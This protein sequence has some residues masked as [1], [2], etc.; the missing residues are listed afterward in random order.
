MSFPFELVC[1]VM[2]LIKSRN[3]QN[4]KYLI[5]GGGVYVTQ[6]IIT[7]LPELKKIFSEHVVE[8]LY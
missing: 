2:E 1:I 8:H 4:T 3:L 6:C 7:D 5:R